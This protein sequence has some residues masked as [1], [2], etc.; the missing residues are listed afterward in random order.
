MTDKKTK[1][2]KS[3]DNGDVVRLNTGGPPMTVV[4]MAPP[5]LGSDYVAVSWFGK[6]GELR[7][8]TSHRRALE[9]VRSVS[10]IH[11]EG[12]TVVELNAVDGRK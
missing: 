2:V 10:E 9:V 4:G 8:M 7:T 3:A 12:E 11:G 5:Q 1:S 6:D